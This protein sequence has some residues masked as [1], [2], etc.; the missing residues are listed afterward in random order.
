MARRLAAIMFTDI[1]GYTALTQTDEAGAFRLLQDQERLVRGLLEVHRGR[2]VKSMGDGLLIEF[3]N[4][5]DALTCAM[6][7]QRHIRERNVREPSPELQVRVGI[8]VGDVEGVGSDILG[9]A[10]N[11]ASRIEPLADPGGV[12]ISE[13]VFAQV[14]NKVAFPLEKLGPKSLKGVQE[15]IDVYRV[16]LP[17]AAG[18]KPPGGPTPPRLAVLPLTN[19][20]PDPKDEYFADGL[21]EEL[22]STISKVRDLSVIS[23][24]SVMPY[25]TH[26]KRVAEIARELG[27]GTILEG[28]VRWA[29]NRVR[30][31]VQLIDP[32][33]D[34]HLW[35]ENYDRNLEDIFAIQ[36]EIAE[37]V[38]SALEVQL[39]GEDKER[40]GTVPTE[41]TEAHLLYM[42][43]QFHYQHLTKEELRTALWYFEQAIQK[44]PRY[45]RAQAAVA[46]TYVWLAWFEMMPS[47]EA[48]S[49]VEAASKKAL[50][51]DP[52]LA[53]AHLALAG[54][55]HSSWDFKGILREA[56]RALELNPSLSEG[57]LLV[58]H[59]YSFVRRF[60]E[61]WTEAQ[62][63]LELDPL[64]SWTIRGA[65]D[66]YLYGGRPERAAELYERVLAIDPTDSFA[67]GN[68]GLCFVRQ[69]RYDE[70]IAKIRKANEM[71]HGTNPMGRA[72]VVYALSKAG[73]TEEARKI[74]SELVTYHRERGVG[75]LAVAT[76]FASV[77][78]RDAA[79]DWLEKA[80]QEHSMGLVDISVDFGFEALHEDP[81]FEKWLKKI[82]V[83][84]ELAGD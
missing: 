66:T 2:L 47:S 58:A 31:T 79:F 78:D 77:G 9:D 55:L 37:K 40:I 34:R 5:L 72:D 82:G 18:E 53:E 75:A 30:V 76:S 71:E 52:T 1:A 84:V 22:I 43:G 81:R 64:S 6:D 69:G 61:A 24:T 27:A 54:A 44:D 63:A 23:R 29:G 70:G 13:H 50:E 35:A 14:R 21:T 36:S 39:R 41:V 26:P 28:S 48:I 73:Q 8:H 12:C 59:L 74:V 42:K 57:R 10:V 67:L 65:A 83:P 25:K 45:A 3:S 38:A 56:Q 80:Y 4:A 16:E 46:G 51:L 68:L 7:L 11:I 17:G 60:E 62:K 49:K 32:V 33:A 20:S 15:P 19:M